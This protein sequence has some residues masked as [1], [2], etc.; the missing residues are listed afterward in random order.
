MIMQLVML[1]WSYFT[2]VFTDPGIVPPNW[3]PGVD[4]ERGEADPLNGV[5]LS[6]MQSDPSNQRMRYCRKCSQPKPA[7]CHHCS[8]CEFWHTEVSIFYIAK[9]KQVRI[10]LTFFWFDTRWTLCTEDGPPLCLGC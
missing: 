4:E 2:V 1:L 5:E 3:K 7:R 10:S 6:N 9:L 8:V